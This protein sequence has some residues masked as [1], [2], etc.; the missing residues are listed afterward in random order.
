[1]IHNKNIINK[2]TKREAKMAEWEGEYPE[3]IYENA[4]MASQY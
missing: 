2:S 4:I 1:M 3:V